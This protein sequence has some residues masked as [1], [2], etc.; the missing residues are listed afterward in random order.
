MVLGKV[1]P[2]TTSV[3]VKFGSLSMGWAKDETADA[4]S[5]TIAKQNVFIEQPSEEKLKNAYSTVARCKAKFYRVP[6]RMLFS[7]A[8]DTAT[9]PIRREKST[10]ASA[11]VQNRIAIPTMRSHRRLQKNSGPSLERNGP[12]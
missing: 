10:S 12:L 1:R 2:D 5:A 7:R 6:P 3:T 9:M 8:A 4:I 11:K